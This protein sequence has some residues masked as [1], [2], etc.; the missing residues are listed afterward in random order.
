M[1]QSVLDSANDAIDKEHLASAVVDLAQRVDDW[2]SLK[3][4]GFGE[5]LRFGTFTVLKGDTAK[6]SEREVCSLYVTDVDEAVVIGPR[7]AIGV[8]SQNAIVSG[9]ESLC[10]HSSHEDDSSEWSPVSFDTFDVFEDRAS[11]YTQQYHRPHS[12]GQ[13]P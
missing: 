12:A 8:R 2:K 7:S 10:V 4:D 6:D 11:I 3:V 13:G 1:I 9:D 5:L